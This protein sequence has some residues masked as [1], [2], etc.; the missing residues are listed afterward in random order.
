[1]ASKNLDVSEEMELGGMNA[2]RAYPEGE[3]FADQGYVATLEARMQLPKYSALPGHLE[4]IG[5]VDTGTVTFHTNPWFDGSNRRTL[6]AAGVGVNWGE[7]GNFLVRAYYAVK[8]GNEKALSSPDR[9][10][11]FWIQAVKYF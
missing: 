6:S 3:A 5:F 10:G 1:M 7:A 9:S 2:V 11:R 4:L 8:L